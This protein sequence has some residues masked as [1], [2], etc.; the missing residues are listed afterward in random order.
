MFVF[1][2]NSTTLYR[3]TYINL[4]GQYYIIIAG[5]LQYENESENDSSKNAPFFMQ[6]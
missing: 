5:R 2:A 6:F 1:Y 4:D 3:I